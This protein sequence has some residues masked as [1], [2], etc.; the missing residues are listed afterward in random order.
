MKLA[1]FSYGTNESP[2]TRRLLITP[3]EIVDMGLG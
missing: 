3:L 2:I 1:P